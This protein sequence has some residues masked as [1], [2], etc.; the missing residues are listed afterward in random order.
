MASPVS[1][2][3]TNVS[4][5]GTKCTCNLVAAFAG[6]GGLIDT[7]D[8]FPAGWTLIYIRGRSE[9]RVSMRAQTGRFAVRTQSR[10]IGV[11]GT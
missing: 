5:S 1:P 10:Y 7:R 4:D 3:G 2:R 6:T 8:L 9:I 11:V